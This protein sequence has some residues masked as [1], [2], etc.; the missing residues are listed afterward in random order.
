MTTIRNGAEF[1]PIHGT[2]TDWVKGNLKLK[3]VFSFELRGSPDDPTRFELSDEEI[4][5]NSDEILD[6]LIAMF[7]ENNI[8]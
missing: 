3:Y 7:S 5:P 1:E 8:P 2:S 4:V 6:A